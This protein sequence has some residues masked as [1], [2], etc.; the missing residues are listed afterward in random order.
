MILKSA[1]QNGRLISITCLKLAEWQQNEDDANDA[2][3]TISKRFPPL[4]ISNLYNKSFRDH[5]VT[6]AI[7]IS[8][9]WL[10][11]PEWNQEKTVSFKPTLRNIDKTFRVSL[12]DFGR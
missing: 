8:V 11:D 7:W 3:D 1:I 4:Q 6:F 10:P 9:R 2:V 5:L 12:A